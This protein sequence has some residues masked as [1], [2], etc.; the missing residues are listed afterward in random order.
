MVCFWNWIAFPGLSIVCPSLNIYGQ[1]AD[2]GHIRILIAPDLSAAL[3]TISHTMFLS[4][5]TNYLGLTDTVL[6]WFQSYHSNR[7]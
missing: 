4:S 2:F 3:V 6:S 5:L 7:T 1:V